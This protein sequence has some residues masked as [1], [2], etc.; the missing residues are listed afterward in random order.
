LDLFHLHIGRKKQELWS[1]RGKDGIRFQWG[2]PEGWG[3][4]S[5]MIPLLAASRKMP[6][7]R[8][9]LL[10]LSITRVSGPQI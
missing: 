9:W 2:S 8:Q 5:S 3:S 7:S 6:Q 10:F 4:F 1:Q